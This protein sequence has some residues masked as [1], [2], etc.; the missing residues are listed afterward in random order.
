MDRKLYSDMNPNEQAIYTSEELIVLFNNMLDD[1]KAMLAK[2]LE[3]DTICTKRSMKELVEEI[4]GKL[5]LE[6]EKVK[7]LKEQKDYNNG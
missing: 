1:Y 7:L 6:L 2:G 3:F 5:I 4:E